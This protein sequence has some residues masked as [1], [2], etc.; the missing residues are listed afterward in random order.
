MVKLSAVSL[1]ALAALLLAG[2]APAQ[3]PASTGVDA[4]RDDR[5]CTTGTLATDATAPCPDDVSKFPTGAFP[6]FA[7]PPLI[8]GDGSTTP[9]IMPPAAAS[10]PMTGTTV[11]SPAPSAGV[12]GTEAATASGSRRPSV[13]R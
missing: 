12:A 2:S 13:R 7:R 11:V 3:T 10:M 1:A 5:R 9:A 8:P 4:S 6:S